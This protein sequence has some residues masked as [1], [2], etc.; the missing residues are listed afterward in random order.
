MHSNMHM[1]SNYI[2]NA[3]IISILQTNNFQRY[4]FK[5]KKAQYLSVQ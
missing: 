3:I 4:N 5:A 2:Y 1:Y